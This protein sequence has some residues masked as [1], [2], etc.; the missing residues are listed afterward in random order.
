[1]KEFVKVPSAVES[2]LS[3]GFW[4]SVDSFLYTLTILPIRFT[5][6][7]LLLL[8]FGFIKA[9][10]GFRGRKQAVGNDGA[11]PGPFQFHRRHCYQLVQVSIIY[12]IYTCVLKPINISIIYHW[13]RVQSMVKLYLLLRLW[14]SLID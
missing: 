6:S 2:L 14:R 9:A 13:I 11:A 7:L 8:R 12:I 3:F 1:M 4:L 10:K 5:W